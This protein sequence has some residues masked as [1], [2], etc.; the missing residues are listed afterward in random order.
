[1]KGRKTVSP[2]VVDWLLGGDK[3]DCRLDRIH[4]DLHDQH[5]HFDSFTQR[6]GDYE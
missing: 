2:G 5:H 6:L 3:R 4:A 1:M